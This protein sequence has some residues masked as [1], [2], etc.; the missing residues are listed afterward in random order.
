MCLSYGMKLW[1]SLEIDFKCFQKNIYVKMPVKDSSDLMAKFYYEF[2][3]KKRLALSNC[4]FSN[5]CY[6]W[7][8]HSYN[9]KFIF[10]FSLL[11]SWNACKY[12]EKKCFM[13]FLV[14]WKLHTEMINKATMNTGVNEWMLIERIPSLHL[15]FP[16]LHLF[17]SLVSAPLFISKTEKKGLCVL[18]LF[19][20]FGVCWDT[21]FAVKP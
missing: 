1:N 8:R 10:F 2:K 11:F 14:F 12:C 13:V 21:V 9:L 20:S 15:S 3:K 4:I 19:S 7:E 16:S 6:Q 18:N 5:F 17:Y